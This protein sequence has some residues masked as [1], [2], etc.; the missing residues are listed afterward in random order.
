LAADEDDA[1]NDAGEFPRSL[2]ETGVVGFFEQ[3]G[4]AVD[5]LAQ[6]VDFSLQ[7]KTQQEARRDGH[8]QGCHG[9]C[10]V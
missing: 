9:A 8:G 1:L 3:D 7:V 5:Q 2:L 4:D 10:Q 6:G